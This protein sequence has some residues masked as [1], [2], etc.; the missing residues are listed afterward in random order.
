MKRSY[1]VPMLLLGSVVLVTG[2]YGLRAARVALEYYEEQSHHYIRKAD[3]K[4]DRETLLKSLG[5]EHR[6][7]Y[8]NMRLHALSAAFVGL[9]FIAWAFDRRSMYARLN[10]TKQVP[11]V[12]ARQKARMQ[13]RSLAFCAL[14]LMFATAA[15]VHM[16]EIAPEW[17]N[18]M[19]IRSRRLKNERVRAFLEEKGIPVERVNWGDGKGGKSITLAGPEVR[20]ISALAELPIRSLYLR[21]TNVTDLSPLSKSPLRSLFL[22]GSQVSDISPLAGTEI[23]SLFLEGTRI[24]DLQPLA[25]MPKLERVH[26]SKQ[27]IMDNL[28]VLRGLDVTV[29]ELPDGPSLQTGGTAWQLEYEAA[30]ANAVQRP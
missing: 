3:V 20:D 21:D 23:D 16:R 24:S 17:V 15:V 26:L 19:R 6:R 30:D 9:V 7:R 28:E 10:A 18:H 1:F 14:L 13:I 12:G 11:T 2:L 29:K 25:Q 8:E 22:E 4:V 27:Q 5:P